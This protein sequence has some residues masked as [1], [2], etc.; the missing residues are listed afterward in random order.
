VQSSGAGTVNPLF[1]VLYKRN[2]S[3]D[4]EV[5]RASFTTGTATTKYIA[6]TNTIFGGVVNG[7]SVASSSLSVYDSS[8]TANS[9]ITVIDGNSSFDRHMYDVAVSSGITYSSTGNG[10]YTILYKRR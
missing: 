10:L 5:W 7:D 4:Y 3:Q 1:I 2:P 6:G 8:A 9:L